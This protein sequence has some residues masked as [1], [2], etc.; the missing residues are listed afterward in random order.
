MY[1]SPCPVELELLLPLT[2][3]LLELLALDPD[4]LLLL[5]KLTWVLLLVLRNSLELLEDDGLLADD[6]LLPV[7]LDELLLLECDTKVEELL[8]LELL[9]K[10]FAALV[11][12][13]ITALF[14]CN[15]PK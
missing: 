1:W 15:D 5:D 4:E 3:V 6:W 12:Y 7:W 11:V 13:G 8:L 9:E 10:R 2:A 14:S